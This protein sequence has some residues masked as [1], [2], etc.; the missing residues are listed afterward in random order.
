MRLRHLSALGVRAYLK[1]A[2]AG[3]GRGHS[4]L[5]RSADASFA[6][7][8]RRGLATSGSGSLMISGHWVST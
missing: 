6:L 2:K 1:L 4:A 7:A 3:I 5:V 8:M